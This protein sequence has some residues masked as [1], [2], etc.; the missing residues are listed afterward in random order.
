MA[1]VAV[2]EKSA[3]KLELDNGIVDGRQKILSK[4]F[5]KVK[6]DATDD[7]LHSTAVAIA[8]LQNKD[9]LKVKRVEE[10][11]LVSQ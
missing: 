5:A 10:V 6:I 4:S 3:L 11:S 2:K 7:G 8:N 9:L 1:I